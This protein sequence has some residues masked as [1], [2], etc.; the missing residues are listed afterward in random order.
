MSTSIIPVAV[1]VSGDGPVADISSLVGPKTVILT[2]TFVGVYTLFASHDGTTFGPILT[3]TSDEPIATT[4]PDSYAYA[5]VRANV[6]Q[7]QS[8]SLT[9]A[10]EL[11]T[12]QNLFAE[13]A[14]FAPGEGGSSPVVD[15]ATLFPPTGLEEG[16]NF[17]C[18]GA[19]SSGSILVEGSNDGALFSVVG[20]FQGGT[21]A[22]A[23]SLLGTATVL[24]FTPLSTVDKIRYVRV[25]VQGLASQVVTVTVGGRNPAAISH[26]SVTP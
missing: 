18:D 19:L 7:A 2:G 11:G 14:S 6:T 13:V 22:S 1:P 20:I 10:G 3:F 17:I 9:V 24:A 12:G 26:P 15:L 21:S 8:V 25:T 4:L 16:L 5:R 23:T